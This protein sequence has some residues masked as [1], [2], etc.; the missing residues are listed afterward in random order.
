MKLQYL[1]TAAYE[2]L[3][4][5]FCRCENCIRARA[6]GGKNIRTRSQAIVDDKLLVDFPADTYMHYINYDIKL[7]DIKACIIT[8]SHSDHLYPA[9]LQARAVYFNDIRHNNPL[10]VYGGESAYNQMSEKIKE[11]GTDPNWWHPELIKP[12]ERFEADGYSVTPLNATHDQSSSPYI[13]LIEKDDKVLFYSNDTDIYPEETWEFLK[14]YKKKINLVSFD[15]TKGSEKMDY[16]GHLSVPDCVEI[17]NR[18]C[19]MGLCDDDTKYVLTHF[20]H[21]GKDCLYDDMVKA[22]EKDNFVV[23]YDGMTIEF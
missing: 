10:V 15:C 9:D 13:F 1:G 4:A 5:F 3:P 20:S 2:G 8:H 19:E 6:I 22:V 23:A 12:F 16:V 21:N 17:R 7:Y 18:L 11:F 14:N